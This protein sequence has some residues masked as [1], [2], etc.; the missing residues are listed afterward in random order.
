MDNIKNEINN[1][2]VDFDNKTSVLQH[3]SNYKNE[4]KNRRINFIM[5]VI[6]FLT[7]LLVIFPNWGKAIADWI[8]NL[9][10][11]IKDLLS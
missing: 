2:V 10:N 3:L 7:L 11:G 6:A 1:V 9:F 4:S 5:L 8:V